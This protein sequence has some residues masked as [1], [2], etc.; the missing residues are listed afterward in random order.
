M[1]GASGIG[2]TPERIQNEPGAAKSSRKAP[3]K[4]RAKTE[5]RA[6]SQEPTAAHQKKIAEST[7]RASAGPIQQGL[8]RAKQ[9]IKQTVTPQASGAPAAPSR[10]FDVTKTGV[11]TP[12]TVP[13]APQ[14]AASAGPAKSRKLPPPIPQ[15][16][17]APLA[18]E[19]PP[20]QAAVR[21]NPK[22]TLI[23]PV[24]SPTASARAPDDVIVIQHISR[25]PIKQAAKDIPKFSLEDAKSLAKNYTIVGTGSERRIVHVKDRTIKDAFKMLFQNRVNAL[26]EF[27]KANNLT[28]EEMKQLPGKVQ[29]ATT[30]LQKP[31]G[32]KLALNWINALTTNEKM[33]LL[34]ALPNEVV[35][36]LLGEASETPQG[37]AIAVML[38]R[39]VDENGFTASKESIT[40][41]LFQ[42]QKPAALDVLLHLMQKVPNKELVA[43]A[44]KNENMFRTL[45]EEQQKRLALALYEQLHEREFQALPADVREASQ[46]TLMDRLLKEQQKQFAGDTSNLKRA[47][48]DEKSK[49]E[50][51]KMTHS[52]K[53]DID[54]LG[55]NK[56]LPRSPKEE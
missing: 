36:P 3:P 33:A 18:E 10:R 55:R 42:P 23:H 53:S 44:K 32:A 29:A 9:P 51:E 13:Q 45:D 19:A 22:A 54:I 2:G 4:G 12:F 52:I 5:G 41:Q 20:A 34:K 31:E 6:I 49:L 27:A 8:P 11:A 15:K 24:P 17:A 48:I 37:H 16:A 47:N 7:A 46:K 14:S 1:T 50:I 43:L 35:L 25:V 28:R 30:E 38:Q 21:F 40:T 26:V 56:R 39:R